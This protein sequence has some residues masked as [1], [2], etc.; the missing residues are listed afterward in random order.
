LR[1]LAGSALDDARVRRAVAR[2]IDRERIVQVALAGY[3][4]PASSP[5]PPDSPLAWHGGVQR[6][7]ADADRLLDAAGWRRGADGVRV[8]DGKRFEVELLSVRRRLHGDD[9]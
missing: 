8:R 3:G 2:S 1:F 4:R 5:V 6:D 9:D 7:I